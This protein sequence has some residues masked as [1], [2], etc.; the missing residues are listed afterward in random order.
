M[1]GE[2]PAAGQVAHG[3]LT[4]GRIN[5]L[6]LMAQVRRDALGGQLLFLALNGLVQG[7][8][9]LAQVMGQPAGAAGVEAAFFIDGDLHAL[10]PGGEA[11]SGRNPCGNAADNNDLHSLSLTIPPKAE[12]FDEKTCVRVIICSG[13][14]DC[15]QCPR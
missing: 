5:A 9:A 2:H 12:T 1:V 11:R 13:W 6:Y 3:H 10:L 7:V 15:P 4:G 8:Q 14:E